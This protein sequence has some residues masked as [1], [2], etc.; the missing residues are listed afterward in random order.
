MPTIESHASAMTHAPSTAPEAPRRHAARV[1]L[2]GGA[3]EAAAMAQALA[4]AGVA[5]VF[6]Y[7]GRTAAPRAQP[8]PTRVGGFGGAAGLAAYLRAG[9][10]T[11]VI[12]ATHPFAAT[13]SRNAIAACAATATPLIALQRAP[14]T[15][16]PR[17]R[18]TVVADIAAAAQALDRPAER[19]FLAIG[20]Q[21]LAAFADR[22]QHRYLLRFVDPP[23]APPP[24][25]DACVV[26]SRGPFTE[27]GDCA[28]MRAHGVTRVVAKNAGGTGARA[29]IDAARAL[30]LPVVMIDRPAIAP[31][32]RADSVAAVMAWLAGHPARL[33][34]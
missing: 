26:V 33:G 2:L 23:Q 6:S 17:D 31:R 32:P 30:G 8:L 11:H 25:A 15:A 20:R 29:K 28:L 14:W 18:W 34:V 13:M 5:A 27:A 24:L 21:N 9:G 4:Q 10:F 12:D 19:V 22:P 7:A 1:L 3:A 16:Q